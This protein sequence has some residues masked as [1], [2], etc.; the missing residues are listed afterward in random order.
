MYKGLKAKTPGCV[1]FSL[2]VQRRSL[3][4]FE[5]SSVFPIPPQP[6]QR[7]GDRERRVRARAAVGPR[8]L[9]CSRD[10]FRHGITDYPDLKVPIGVTAPRL[11]SRAGSSETDKAAPFAANVF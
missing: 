5:D 10:G 2:P 7:A 9:F 8:S 6:A 3:R 11:G 4:N 1:A